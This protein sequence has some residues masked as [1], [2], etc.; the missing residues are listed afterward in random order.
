M[1]YQ[2]RILNR[3]DELIKEVEDELKE[4]EKLKKIKYRKV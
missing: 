3:I 2:G 1:Y 4:K